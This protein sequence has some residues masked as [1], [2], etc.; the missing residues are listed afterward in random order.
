MAQQLEVDTTVEVVGRIYDIS[1]VSRAKQFLILV[2][3]IDAIRQSVKTVRA[4]KRN[5]ILQERLIAW[6]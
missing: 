1:F 2:G 5:T 4:D 3:E 6:H